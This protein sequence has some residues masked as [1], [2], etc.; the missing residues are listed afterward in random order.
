MIVDRMRL[1][2]WTNIE[3][4]KPTE[5][6]KVVIQEL[7]LV[8]YFKTFE[9]IPPSLLSSRPPY[10]IRKPHDT[11][12]IFSLLPSE[13]E[14]AS[15]ASTEQQHYNFSFLN[16]SQFLVGNLKVERSH[17]TFRKIYINIFILPNCITAPL[18]SQQWH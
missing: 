9:H 18:D 13:M 1:R 4:L 11:W 14:S 7:H 15:D 12:N 3:S 5:L 2:L 6:P 17:L 8:A 16:F 10:Q